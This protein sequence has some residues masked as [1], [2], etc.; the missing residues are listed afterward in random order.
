MTV[1]KLKLSSRLPLLLDEA[2][3]VIIFVSSM[4]HHT[5]LRRDKEKALWAHMLAI[6]D[7]MLQNIRT[8]PSKYIKPK[9]LTLNSEP[10]MSHD[11]V[12]DFA[13]QPMP[14]ILS[15]ATAVT[16]EILTKMS[17]HILCAPQTTSFI[18]S[19]H[20]CVIFDP[21]PNMQLLALGSKSI[22]IIFPISPQLM[23]IFFWMLPIEQ[24]QY[25]EINESEEEVDV[26]LLFIN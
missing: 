11:E 5:K 6:G 4:L 17:A 24:F 20:P 9:R 25:M 13:R 15:T 21:D 19:E 22:E 3:T 2:A 1:R 16:A 10:S 18:T 23:V 26:I 7:D 12:R 8:N 14:N